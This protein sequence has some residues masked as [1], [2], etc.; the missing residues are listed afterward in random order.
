MTRRYRTRNSLDTMAFGV[1]LSVIL[2]ALLACAVMVIDGERVGDGT[3]Q[4]STTSE[5]AST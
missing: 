2:A 5:A 1:V 4:R 3:A